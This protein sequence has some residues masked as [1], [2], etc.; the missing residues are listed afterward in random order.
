MSL[1]TLSPTVC[2]VN[3]AALLHAIAS[4]GGGVKVVLILPI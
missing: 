3:N 1:S 4:S 2:I